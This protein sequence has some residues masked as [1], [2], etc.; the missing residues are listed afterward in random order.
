M[1]HFVKRMASFC[2]SNVLHFDFCRAL[3][4]TLMVTT[5]VI[6]ARRRRVVLYIHFVGMAQVVMV[7]IHVVQEVVVVVVAVVVQQEEEFPTTICPS[8]RSIF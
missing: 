8:Q 7:T 4:N 6:P 2:I 3:C 5:R 1:F